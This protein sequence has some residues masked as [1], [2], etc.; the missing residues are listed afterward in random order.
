[1]AGHWPAFAVHKSFLHTE[2]AGISLPAGRH[3]KPLTSGGKI[4]REASPAEPINR[5]WRIP[6]HD[7]FRAEQMKAFAGSHGKRYTAVQSSVK[8]SSRKCAAGTIGSRLAVEPAEVTTFLSEGLYYVDEEPLWAFFLIVC[9]FI[10]SLLMPSNRVC[11]H[12]R[13]TSVSRS[14]TSVVE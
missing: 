13:P 1:M 3:D 10:Q 5:Q 9:Q 4:A 2:A 8:L 12:S 11:R 7:Y 14:R 6:V